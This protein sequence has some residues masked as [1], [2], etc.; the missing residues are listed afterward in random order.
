MSISVDVETLVRSYTQLLANVSDVEESVYELLDMIYAGVNDAGLMTSVL[1]DTVHHDHALI[2]KLLGL[3][4]F[5]AF[6]STTTP[7][8]ERAPCRYYKQAGRLMLAEWDMYEREV[9]NIN[10]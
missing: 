5:I 3:S 10:N 9:R 8:D 7:P 1:F 6:E 4:R 2:T